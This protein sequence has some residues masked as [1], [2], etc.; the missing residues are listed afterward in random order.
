MA[1]KYPLNRGLW[2]LKTAMKP[3]FSAWQVLRFRWVVCAVLETIGYWTWMVLLWEFVSWLLQW[4][5]LIKLF[6]ESFFIQNHS[7]IKTDFFSVG[8]NYDKFPNLEKVWEIKLK[9]IPILIFLSKIS[10]L[11]MESCMVFIIWEV[12]VGVIHLPF[13]F[14]L[15]QIT[16]RIIVE[17]HCLNICN[18][19][20]N[21]FNWGKILEPLCRPSVEDDPLSFFDDDTL[22]VLSF[23]H[24]TSFN[25]E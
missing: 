20:A 18:Y 22:Q 4:N 13:H 1:G 10:I 2:T 17:N 23:F 6:H 24:L 12:R 7:L 21:K 15:F 19:S 14:L 3:P 25:P 16:E 11:E 9:K 5:E 8:K